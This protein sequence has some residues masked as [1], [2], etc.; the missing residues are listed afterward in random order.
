MGAFLGHG[1]AGAD[2]DGLAGRPMPRGGDP[3]LPAFKAA[4]RRP[5]AAPQKCPLVRRRIGW[6]VGCLELP[7]G[8][9]VPPLGKQD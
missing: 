1:G 7:E 9:P 4:H 8:F 3:H 6:A 5:R 2:G